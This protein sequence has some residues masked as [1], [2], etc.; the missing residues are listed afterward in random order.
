MK[1]NAQ[2]TKPRIVA[3]VSD[4]EKQLWNIWHK[5]DLME[6][7][8]PVIVSTGRK[9]HPPKPEVNPSPSKADKILALI[10]EIG[11]NQVSWL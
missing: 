8:A 5:V 6:P 3:T 1:I 7:L 4:E 10:S 11:A 2:A 9:P